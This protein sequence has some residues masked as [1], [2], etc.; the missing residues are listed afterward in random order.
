ML[1]LAATVVVIVLALLIPC[2]IVAR[3]LEWR[4]WDADRRITRLRDRR[5]S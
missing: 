4:A 3:Y 1:T 5:T 2:L